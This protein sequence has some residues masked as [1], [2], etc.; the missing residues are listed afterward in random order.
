MPHNDKARIGLFGGT[1]NPIHNGHIKMAEAARKQFKLK[2]VYFIPCG[3]PPHRAKDLY[4]AGLRYKLVAGTVKNKKYFKVL[5]I[6]VRKKKPCYTIDTVKELIKR[7]KETLYFLIGADEFEN[8]KTWKS[9]DKLAKMVTFLVL[10]RPEEKV[11]IPKIKG[12]KWHMVHAKPINISSTE[13]R[14][15]IK[16]KKS[17]KDLVPSQ[18]LFSYQELSV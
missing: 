1:F 4:P 3:I 15:K 6:E 16:E 12:L 5:D 10:P 2:C 8:L 14:K 11:K 13:I 18:L 7:S 17:I 9:P